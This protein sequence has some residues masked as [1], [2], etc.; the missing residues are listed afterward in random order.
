[1]AL[2]S[3][4]KEKLEPIPQTAL[5]DAVAFST[6]DRALQQVNSV[7]A[8]L[9]AGQLYAGRYMVYQDVRGEEF[10]N[11]TNN[12]VT[13]FLTWNFTVT[14]TANEVLGL[15]EAGFASINRCNVVMEGLSTSPIADALKKQYIA[16]AKTVR[17]I[18]YFALLQL[19]ARPFADG[20]GSK[21][22]LP[23]RL[24][25]EKSSGTN[26][27]ARSSV[28]DIY[29]QILKDL[30]EAETDLP[31]TYASA[32]LRTTRAHKNTAR[33]FKSRVYL[34]MGRYADVITEAQKIVPTTGTTWTSP[35]GVNGLSATIG[36]VFTTY[37]NSE[38]ILSMPFTALNLPGTQNSLGSYY[39]PGPNGNGDYA[40]NATG[41][42]IV[43]NVDWKT[44]DARRAFNI[45]DGGG[46]L[47]LRKWP[48]NAGS[49]PDWA[50]VIRYSE[51]MLN[52]AEAL[53]RQ[54][55]AVDARAVA[56]LNAVRQ[57]SDA[58]T[59]FAPATKTDL[60][61]LILTERRIELLGEGHRT[62]DITRLL[63]PFPAKG[64][65]SALP[66][67]APQYVWPISNNELITNKACVQNEGY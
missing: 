48:K 50:Q 13:A 61:N 10:L 9:K 8:A 38:N 16:E 24:N 23:M 22:G 47:R 21:P 45:A 28:A 46:L 3:C 17:A 14:P 49:D 39:N 41:N 11:I 19:Y 55:S 5:S 59:T 57:R 40:L 60:I 31:D 37:N 63:Q 35:N 6:P 64:S 26:D 36:A 18:S 42:G 43:A 58:T 30:N 34:N 66:T 65:V 32:D 7:Y 56:L 67:T 25:A 12:G 52:L 4:S 44:A 27:L 33:A 29:N 20:N 15:W 2:G 51:V 53:A 62:S 54:A 1:V